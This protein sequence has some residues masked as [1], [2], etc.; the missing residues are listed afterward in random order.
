MQQ[1]GVQVRPWS[2][3]E[4]PTEAA[5]HRIY[6]E[7]GL[8]PC[9][10]SNAPGDTYSAH[11]HDFHKVLYCVRGSITF[12]L[13]DERRSVLLRPGDRLDLPA[14]VAHDATVGPDGVTC[15]EAH[16]LDILRERC[17]A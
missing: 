17:L 1:S 14:G 4:P 10:W 13:P 3:D 16:R 15:F 2:N 6:R 7:E 8:S 5:I 9:S 11:S 12:G